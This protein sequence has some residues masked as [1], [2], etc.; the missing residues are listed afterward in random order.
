MVAPLATTL[1]G[2]V[3]VGGREV[4][5]ITSAA[6]LRFLRMFNHPRDPDHSNPSAKELEKLRAKLLSTQPVANVSAAREFGFSGGNCLGIHGDDSNSASDV[7]KRV[8]SPSLPK[9]NLPKLK[10]GQ[11]GHPVARHRGVRGVLGGGNKA[12]NNEKV[13]LQKRALLREFR[14][15]FDATHLPENWMDLDMDSEVFV[16]EKAGE[17][18]YGNGTSGDAKPSGNTALITPATREDDTS[19][20]D[21][22]ACDPASAEVKPKI[23]RW[24]KSNEWAIPNDRPF[25]ESQR[26]EMRWLLHEC[27]KL[28]VKIQPSDFVAMFPSFE[29]EAIKK[30]ALRELVSDEKHDTPKPLVWLAQMVVDGDIPRHTREGGNHHGVPDEEL[31]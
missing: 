11:M 20:S 5:D 28:K 24:M 14:K 1:F 19:V 6:T 3:G 7:Q 2:V 15:S 29:T 31:E 13:S 26:R 17:G 8:G 4:H 25:D 22:N 27:Q 12:L 16:G 10:V 9:L 23:V 21:D 18:A 30:A